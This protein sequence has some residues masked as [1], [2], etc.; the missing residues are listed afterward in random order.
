MEIP[1]IG[2]DGCTYR[3]ECARERI[4]INEICIGSAYRKCLKFQEYEKQ[5]ADY[6][7][8]SLIG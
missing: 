1:D 3:S 7:F 4:E 8:D 5:K 2:D 6:V